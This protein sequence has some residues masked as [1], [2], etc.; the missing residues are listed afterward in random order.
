MIWSAAPGREGQLV[1]FKDGRKLHGGLSVATAGVVPFTA[2]RRDGWRAV[3]SGVPLAEPMPGWSLDA[4]GGRPGDP[5][6]SVATGQLT[7]G[8]QAVTMLGV[9][10]RTNCALRSY[11]RL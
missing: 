6:S 11:L 3:H 8:S 10:P 4:L 2:T 9:Y 5:L 7:V 1:A